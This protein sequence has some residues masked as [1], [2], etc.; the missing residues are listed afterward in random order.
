M[1]WV[2]RKMV[3]RKN[4]QEDIFMDICCGRVECQGEGH[5]NSL[6]SSRQCKKRYVEIALDT[7]LSLLTLQRINRED[8]LTL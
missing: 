5:L 8:S 2:Q 6:R 7:Q 1:A 4:S 3:G